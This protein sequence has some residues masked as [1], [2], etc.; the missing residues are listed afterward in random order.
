MEKLEEQDTLFDFDC[1]RRADDVIDSLLR[2]QTIDS[3]ANG[4][5]MA[6]EMA[7]IQRRSSLP[8]RWY[9]ESVTSLIN[10]SPIEYQ[11]QER[12]FSDK[13]KFVF[14]NSFRCSYVGVY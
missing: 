11:S 8:V 13:L 2:L 14:T 6:S 5:N 1:K 3:C 4:I 12:K 7:V 10:F 9:H